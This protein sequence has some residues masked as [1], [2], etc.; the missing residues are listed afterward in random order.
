MSLLTK[1]F[2]H[3]PDP[4]PDLKPNEV[5]VFGANQLGHHYGGS[6]RAGMDKFGAVFG[7]I[8][9][10]GQCYG[11]VTILYPTSTTEGAPQRITKRE[12]NKEFKLFL[13]A[14]KLEPEK[15]FYL[16]KVGLG[17]AGWSLEEVK[18]SFWRYFDLD[19][20]TNV[21]FPIEFLHSFSAEEDE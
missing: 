17:V 14:T 20:H 6:A 21:V 18:D 11:L 10:T 2:K 1:R 13:K 4:M 16:T 3:T 9:R 15:V 5:F 12:L 7:E 19:V 8:H